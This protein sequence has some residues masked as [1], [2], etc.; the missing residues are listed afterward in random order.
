MYLHD[1]YDIRSG[2]LIRDQLRVLC[3]F[4]GTGR[5]PLV[6][7]RPT[8]GG[9]SHTGVCVPELAPWTLS[10]PPK[11]HRGNLCVPLTVRP[12]LIMRH[13]NRP[14]WA[15]VGYSE[16]PGQELS[17]SCAEGTHSGTFMTLA[18]TVLTLW[19]G[20]ELGK[21]EV[22]PKEYLELRVKL[23]WKIYILK[24]AVFAVTPPP[25]PQTLEVSKRR[26]RVFL[27]WI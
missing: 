17:G 12:A 2:F 3:W 22:E 20:P 24:A 14:L 19:E 11:H 25:P 9:V 27:I 10:A 4:S 1:P 13:G 7:L 8:Q 26:K 21:S 18:L 5:R 15:L 16:L 6:P 23:L